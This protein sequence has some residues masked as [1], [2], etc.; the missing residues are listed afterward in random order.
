MAKA[1]TISVHVDGIRQTLAAFRRLPKQASDSLRD[2][3][4]DLSEL[5]ARRIKAAGRLDSRQSAAVAP[6]V[7]AVRDRVPAI[8]AGGTVRVTSTRVP[9]SK[10]IFGSEFGARRRFGWY[11]AHKYASSRGRQYRRH[12][13]RGSYWIFRTVEENAAEISR[14]WAKVADDVVQAWN[15]DGA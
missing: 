10:V 11:A 6:T 1:L 14:A 2:R 13:G 3:T 7:K 9:A 4:L 12:L 15:R 5:L 8:V